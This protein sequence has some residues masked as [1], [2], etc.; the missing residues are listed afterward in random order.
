MRQQIWGEVVVLIQTSLQIPYEFNS[1]KKLW[2]LVH[3]CRSY[4]ASK[5]AGNFWCTLYTC[6]QSKYILTQTSAYLNCWTSSLCTTWHCNTHTQTA[7]VSTVHIYTTLSNSCWHLYERLLS[8]K[9][10]SSHRR[11]NTLE[12]SHSHYCITG[13]III[14]ITTIKALHL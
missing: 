8:S 2:K 10:A 3:L 6:T 7:Q 9:M 1:E 13:I 11:S 14:I 12:K 5:F 4:R